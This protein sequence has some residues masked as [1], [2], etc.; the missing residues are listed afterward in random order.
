MNDPQW[1]SILPPIIAIIL[2]IK[3]KQV[4]PSLFAGIWIGCFLLN[5]FD[6]ITGLAESFESIINVFSDSGDTK[7]LIFTLLIGALINT[8]E[9]SG[10][11]SGFVKFL[12]NRKWVH[13][14]LR[15]Q[16]LAWFTGIVIFI[17]SN[18]TLLVA[19]SVSR[20]LFDRY[21]ISREKLAYLID[22]TSAPVCVMVP[23]N[24]WTAVIIGLVAS[25]GVDNAFEIFI[26]SIPYNL[27]AI[28]AIILALFFIIKQIDIGPM[29]AA[30]ARTQNGQITWQENHVEAEVTDK[31]EDSASQKDAIFMI[32]PILTMTFAMPAGLFLTGAGDIMK[33]SGSTAIFWS[34]C[35]ALFVCWCMLLSKKKANVN[36]LM[37]LFMEGA[38]NLL[39]IACIL[40]MALALGDIA[41]LLGTGPY[42]AGV[43]G[44]NVPVIFL[45]PLVFLVSGFIAFSVGS[46]WGTFAIMIPIAMS[47][48]ATLDLSTSL[49][50]GAALS[51]GIFGDHASPI[52]D[53][54]V[55]ASMAAGTDHIEHVRT[56]LPYA[57]IAGTISVIGFIILS[58]IP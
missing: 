12:E 34:I 39:P 8:I 15:A 41:K 29:R 20:P 13:T 4:I 46:S 37:K 43:A 57:L 30:E 26:R 51:G 33:G 3:T 9:K 56:Q 49:M 47:I 45:A 38:G 7:V 55:V 52:S 23:L 21:R 48:A 5:E 22:A 32:V 6:P 11:V 53:T 1:F 18:I 17:E 36:D 35:A 2:A 10:G 58:M 19:G 16:M 24:A 28:T 40:L 50:L 27:Y 25:T 42:V 44:A 31:E 54:T 14:K